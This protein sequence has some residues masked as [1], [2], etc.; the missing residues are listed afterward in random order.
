[1]KHLYWPRL[2]PGQIVTMYEDHG[3][4]PLG[5]FYGDGH[6]DGEVGDGYG[7]GYGEGSRTGN[8]YR[9]GNGY[10][11]GDSNKGITT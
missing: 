10:G 4:G 7:D 2:L 11:N 9:N 8:S 1:M 3:S 6:G 5:N